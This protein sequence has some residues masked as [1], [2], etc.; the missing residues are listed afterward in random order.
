MKMGILVKTYNENGHS[1]QTYNEN[2]HYCSQLTTK[3]GITVENY[4]R[5]RV[6][7]SSFGQKMSCRGYEHPPIAAHG[8]TLRISTWQTLT[9]KVC[10]AYEV[11]WSLR[12]RRSLFRL[13]THFALQ[14][15]WDKFNASSTANP[16]LGQIERLSHRKR[17]LGTNS[18]PL[19]LHNR[20][21]DKLNAFRTAKDKFNAFRTANPFLG[22]I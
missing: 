8:S 20:S 6:T 15:P 11:G 21:W 10:C 17:L 16:F 12:A 14:T 19:A 1:G 9:Q 5:K 4:K 22:Q 7:S 2:G 3:M 18:T 13:I